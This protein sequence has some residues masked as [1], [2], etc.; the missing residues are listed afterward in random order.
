M[1]DNNT[2]MPTLNVAQKSE[3]QEALRQSKCYKVSN[4]AKTKLCP[5]V[6]TAMENVWQEAKGLGRSI[7]KIHINWVVILALVILA[8]MAKNGAMEDMPNLKWLLESAMRLIEWGIGLL[9]NLLKWAVDFM[10]LPGFGIFDWFKNW[11]MNVF[12]L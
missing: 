5:F 6:K 10:D 11:V 9:R 7:S 12:A 4:W 8:N 1:E 3:N 2:T